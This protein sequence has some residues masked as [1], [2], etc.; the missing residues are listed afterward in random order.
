ME[1]DVRTPDEVSDSSNTHPSRVIDAVLDLLAR[2]YRWAGLICR[3][4]TGTPEW[5]KDRAGITALLTWSGRACRHGQVVSGGP[6]VEG[7][8]GH[9]GLDVERGPQTLVRLPP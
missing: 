5:V 2:S 4:D 1:R 3:P 9:A 7:S 8:R 6:E